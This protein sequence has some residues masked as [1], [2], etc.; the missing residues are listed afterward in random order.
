MREITRARVAKDGSGS[1][2]TEGAQSLGRAPTV[3]VIRSAVHLMHLADR[4][5]PIDG[6]FIGGTDE[7]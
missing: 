3:Q 4:T 7:A 5:K 1:E 6:L 2:G